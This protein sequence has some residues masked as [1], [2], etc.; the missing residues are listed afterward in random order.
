MLGVDPGAGVD[1]IRER[2]RALA[3]ELHPDRQASVVD[4]A[5]G[6]GSNDMA[7]VNQAWSVL[8]DPARRAAY[9]RQ[10][11][12]G[13]R[14]TGAT[15]PASPRYGSPRYGPAHPPPT[16]EAAPLGC[17]ASTAGFLPW[18]ALLAVLAAIFV[19]TA[20]AATDGGEGDGTVRG[21]GDDPPMVAVRDLRGS[22]IQEIRGAAMVVDCFTVPHEG[23]IVAQASVDASCPDGTIEWLIR[24][25]DVLA[26]TE[27]GSEV[28]AR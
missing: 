18:V 19:F 10:L 14:T 6:A 11:R 3:R 2:Y 16:H 27:P 5:D 17:L 25:Q 13:E 22:C 28:R 12:S 1:E 8:G 26:C 15:R 21:D 20:Y 7:A 23:V 24:H 9:D 4:R